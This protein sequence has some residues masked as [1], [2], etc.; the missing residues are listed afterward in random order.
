MDLDLVA[1]LGLKLHNKV[2]NIACTNYKR[3][4]KRMV[5]S[6]YR[7]N[8]KYLNIGG[9]IFVRDHWRVL[10]FI[11]PWYNYLG[12]FVDYD[13]DLESL[14]KFPIDDESFDL[15]YIFHVLEHLSDQAVVHTL[16]ETY[17]ILKPG[18]V[19]IVV[20]DIDLAPLSLQTPTF[21]VVQNV[22]SG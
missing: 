17:R 5:I 8:P 6:K 9:G 3:L 19:R 12:I 11:T 10:D 1:K 20:S 21:K 16:K 14:K 7:D 22:I 4:K 15:V 2:Y 18:G 13:F